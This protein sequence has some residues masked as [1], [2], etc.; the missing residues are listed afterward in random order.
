MMNAYE[1]LM[2]MHNM[3]CI[4]W[5]QLS[6]MVQLQANKTNLKFFNLYFVFAQE[7]ASNNPW[8]SL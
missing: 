2:M 1:V 8:L 3:L 6:F 5:V 4:T 7:V